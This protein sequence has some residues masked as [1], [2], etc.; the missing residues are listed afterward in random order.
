MLVNTFTY[1]RYLSLVAS[2]SWIACDTGGEVAAA[3]DG[4]SCTVIGSV[5]FIHGGYCEMV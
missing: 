1:V 2:S 3:R 4:H 5:M